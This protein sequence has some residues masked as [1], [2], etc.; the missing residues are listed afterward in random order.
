[1]KHLFVLFFIL[2]LGFSSC[3]KKV[4]GVDDLT[5]N[6]Y[7]TAYSGAS[8]FYI[9]E[10]YSFFNTLG[11]PRVMVLCIVPSNATPG[12]KP[13]SFYTT[14]QVNAEDLGLIYAPKE[15][16]GSYEFYLDVSDDGTDSYCVTMAVYNA[17]DSTSINGFTECV[18][19]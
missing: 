9:E 4:E 17:E 18:N 15:N 5:T 7:D 11:Q 19:L 8:W 16:D 13:T 6:I 1:M 14:A 3:L 10:A 2:T 12:L